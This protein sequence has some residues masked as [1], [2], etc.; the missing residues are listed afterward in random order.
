[1]TPD[2][3]SSWSNRPRVVRILSILTVLG[4]VLGLLGVF[5]PKF[6]G[7]DDTYGADQRA[8]VLSRASDYAATYNTYTTSDL[9]DYQKRMK[10]LLTPKYDETFVKITDSV[11]T[12]LKDKKQV[13][14]DPKVRGVAIESIDKDSAVAL[15]AVD[16]T[17]TNTDAA[18]GVL[19]HFRWKLT[20]TR[21]GKD[22]LVS[23]FESVAAVTA[24][25]GEPSATA[26]TP[27]TTTEGG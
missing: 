19:R 2:P 9:A 21:S 7:E 1:M 15:V 23:N 27:T 3:E 5:L 16:A 25:A 12:A 13:S 11:F 22:W 14:G 10:G 17:I 26:P 18:A 24:T 6:I 8:K 4:L 20:F